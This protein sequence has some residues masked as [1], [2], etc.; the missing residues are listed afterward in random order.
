VFIGFD[1]WY[2]NS[3]G[4]GF[5][6]VKRLVKK[7]DLVMKNS[8]GLFPGCAVSALLTTVSRRIFAPVTRRWTITWRKKNERTAA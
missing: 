2:A 4:G 7:L 6:F 5:V 1:G 3:A 8:R